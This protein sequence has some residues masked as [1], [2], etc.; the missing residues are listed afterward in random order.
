MNGKKEKKYELTMRK[1]G[2]KHDNLTTK[3]T[4]IIKNFGLCKSRDFH[5]IRRSRI[6]DKPETR[7]TFCQ[8]IMCEI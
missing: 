3:K 5:K 4:R 6:H 8:S 2:E 1:H 7:K